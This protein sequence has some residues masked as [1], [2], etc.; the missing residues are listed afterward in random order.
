[1]QDAALLYRGAL[2]LQL[3]SGLDEAAE[4]LSGGE[5]LGRV[6]ASGHGISQSLQP[7]ALERFPS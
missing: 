1:L 2:L 5:G 7:Q 6:L 4:P 3:R